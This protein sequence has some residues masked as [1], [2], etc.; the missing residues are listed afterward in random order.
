MSEKG[1]SG[2]IQ[3]I[4]EKIARYCA[5]QERCQLEVRQKLQQLG[6]KWP[7]SEDLL[8]E[9]ISE[10]FV[11]EERFARTFAG[12]RFRVKRWGRLKIAQALRQKDLSEQCI[13]LGLSEI[14]E[15]DYLDT[16]SALI[17]K[18]N[19]PSK[20]PDLFIR[21]DRIAKYLMGKG[22]EPELVWSELKQQI[23]S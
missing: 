19:D 15:A 11:N 5:Y 3:K 12:G 18:R 2:E 22:F 23:T 17:Q 6:L 9:L 1:Q 20:D 16:V 10:G 7:E 14:D 8:A 4:K 13:Q 21:R